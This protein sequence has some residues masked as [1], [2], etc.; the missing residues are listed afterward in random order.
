MSM[1]II[2]DGE[3]VQVAGNASSDL[4]ARVKELEAEVAE[5]TTVETI[6]PTAVTGGSAGT[7]TWSSFI[8]KKQ[9]KIVSVI[10]NNLAHSADVS[11]VGTVTIVTG[12]PKPVTGR[13]YASGLDYG[14]TNNNVPAGIFIDGNGA[15]GVDVGFTLSTNKFYGAF[16]YICTE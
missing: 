5:L 11:A 13:F 12:L 8:V 10:I 2:K 7:V 6:T 15:L 14:G 16:T 9:G 3:Y 4:D 1:G